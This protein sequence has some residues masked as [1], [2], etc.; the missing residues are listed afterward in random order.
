MGEHLSPLGYLVG[1]G[2]VDVLGVRLVGGGRGMFY[3]GSGYG[4]GHFG[5]GRFFGYDSGSRRVFAFGLLKR[6]VVDFL[7]AL[8][9]GIYAMVKLVILSLIKDC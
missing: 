4:F 2:V 7:S 6:A 9:E 5:T 3:G 1:C 8:D